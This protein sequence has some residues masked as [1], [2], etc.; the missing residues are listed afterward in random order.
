MAVTLRII[1]SWRSLS[2]LYS[3]STR[4]IQIQQLVF[5]ESTTGNKMSLTGVMKIWILQK[6]M[7][8][9]LSKNTVSKLYT[10]VKIGMIPR[11]GRF[12]WSSVQT[13]L[14]EW[15]RVLVQKFFGS[16]LCSAF[17]SLL[18]GATVG[19]EREK[20]KRTLFTIRS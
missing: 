14:L 19:E 5:M 20:S 9:S 10:L 11:T 17:I 6:Y 4:I 8:S 7:V 18:A 13:H 1:F 16:R 3:Q 2:T 12:L 15:K